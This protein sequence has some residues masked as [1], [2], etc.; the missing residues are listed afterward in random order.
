MI[1]AVDGAMSLPLLLLAPLGIAASW[2]SPVRRRYWLLLG[3]IVA[4]SIAI[5]LL[6][7]V[8]FAQATFKLSFLQP[9]TSEETLIFAALSA[10]IFLLFVALTFVLLRT[11]LRLYVERKSGVTTLGTDG[12]IVTGAAARAYAVCRTTGVSGGVNDA[13]AK[14][15]M[16]DLKSYVRRHLLGG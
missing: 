1:R 14:Q 7:G 6:F 10:F 5:F 2:S 16:E 4:L 8:I 12:K 3:A 13:A 9:D 15:S 11:L